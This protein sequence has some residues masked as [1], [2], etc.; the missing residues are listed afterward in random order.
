LLIQNFEENKL[1]SIFVALVTTKIY[2]VQQFPFW[3]NI[4]FNCKGDI[5][6][7]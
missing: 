7:L 3:E 4:T 6:N 2:F 5:E 1:E